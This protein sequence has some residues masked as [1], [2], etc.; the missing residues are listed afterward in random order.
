MRFLEGDLSYLRFA[1]TSLLN[2]DTSE[3]LSWLA[4][5]LTTASLFDKANTIVR[6]LFL[7]AD[8]DKENS[9]F[10]SLDEIKSSWQSQIVSQEDV[11]PKIRSF[12]KKLLAFVDSAKLNI[13]PDPTDPTQALMVYESRSGQ[14][15]IEA[16][17]IANA[18]SHITFLYFQ[19]QVAAGQP[20][21]QDYAHLFRQLLE[22]QTIKHSSLYRWLRSQLAM[23][24]DNAEELTEGM[25]EIFVL[26]Y[27]D[28]NN[29]GLLFIGP[30]GPI[31][32]KTPLEVSNEFP[33]YRDDPLSPS[34]DFITYSTLDDRSI[35]WIEAKQ[36]N[37]EFLKGAQVLSP[38]IKDTIRKLTN[39]GQQEHIYGM[40]PITIGELA[41]PKKLV[42]QFRTLDYQTGIQLNRGPK[43]YRLEANG[44]RSL[45]QNGGREVDLGN[46]FKEIAVAIS[47]IPGFERLDE[48]VLLDEEGH[49][50][51]SFHINPHGID[52]TYRPP[53]APKRSE[54][55][56]TLHYIPPGFEGR[57]I[58][59]YTKSEQGPDLS[60]FLRS[61]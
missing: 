10:K 8:H 6:R 27:L 50:F 54:V 56:E 29:Q 25:S 40:I 36:T 24:S 22:S 33:F 34:F 44:H 35:S 38:Y 47:K 49:S 26:N 7:N 14:L 15:Q 19:D 18:A 59:R 45:V 9:S 37:R 52:I 20:D 16:V 60:D 11:H 32:T 23:K 31:E 21:L 1:C 4:E 46:Y 3:K 55:I 30:S 57:E 13:Q 43:S 53:G 58:L 51:A 61:D 48:I 41:G 2:S 12:Y 42:V 5:G 17:N 39:S 28:R